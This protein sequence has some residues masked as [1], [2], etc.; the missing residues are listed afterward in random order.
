ME[1]NK[2]TTKSKLRAYLPIIG[3]GIVLVASA[4]GLGIA[5]INKNKNEAT[6]EVAFNSEF[7]TL[8]EIEA[9]ED[10]VED[11]TEEEIAAL[12]ETAKTGVKDELTLR[13]L[14]LLDDEIEI[15]VSNNMELLAGMKVNGQKTL[16]GDATL[17][18][19]LA[20]EKNT[21]ED[22]V[23]LVSRGN[24]L[25]MEGLVL[26]GNG[27]CHAILV[28]EGATL[29]YNKGTIQYASSYG[30]YNQGTTYVNGGT[31]TK[32]MSAAI[33][34]KSGA[35]TYVTGG[36]IKDNYKNHIWSAAGSTVEVTGGVFDHSYEHGIYNRGTLTMT[37]GTI[38]NS[39]S[40]NACAVANFGKAYIDGGDDYIEISNCV[41]GFFSE[42]DS[43]EV[44]MVYGHD[45]VRNFLRIKEGKGKVTNCKVENTG[46]YAVRAGGEV[47]IENIYA[48]NLGTHG[49]YISPG[50]V[51]V[52]NVEVKN[53]K[54]YGFV[55][56]GGEAT[57]T[58][59]KITGAGT[60]AFINYDS[61]FNGKGEKGLLT[62]KDCVATDC[63]SNLLVRGG[64][65]VKVSDCVF[66]KT[67]RTNVHMT[68]GTAELTN[69]KLLGASDKDCSIVSVRKDA[70]ATFTNVEMANGNRGI[71]L[72]G[73]ITVNGGSIHDNEG[74][75][76][77]NA[78]RAEDNAVYKLEGV[79]IYSNRNTSEKMAGG[80]SFMAK[81]SHG[82]IV[83]CEITNN[84]SI[85]TVGG[86]YAEKAELNIRD[87]VFKN[88]ST[89]GA[90]GK[91]GAILLEKSKSII[92]GC[93]FEENKTG[94]AYQ[95]VGGAIYSKAGS[96]LQII[97][98]DFNKNASG[99]GGAIANTGSLT[100]KEGTTFTSN[101]C[102]EGG[103]AVYNGGAGNITDNGSTYKTNTL[104]EVHAGGAIRNDGTNTKYSLVGVVLKE[105][106]SKGDGGAIYNTGTLKATDG[107]KFI[108]N[109][110]RQGGALYNKGTVTLDNAIFDE[111][112]YEG[113]VGSCIYNFAKAKLNVKQVEMKNIGTEKD[114]HAILNNG[115]TI[116]TVKD[117]KKALVIDN[118]V[119]HGVVNMGSGTTELTGVSIKDVTGADRYGVYSDSGSVILKDVAIENVTKD[120]VYVKGGTATVEDAT[121]ENIV[122]A[123]ITATETTDDD[124]NV[125][126]IGEVTL[127]DVTVKLPEDAEA[128]AKSAQ[129]GI[130]C[131]R[132]KVNVDNVNISNTNAE[133]VIN[134]GGTI[135]TVQGAE[136]SI[137]IVNANGKG[138]YSSA[139]GTFGTE[140]SLMKVVEVAGT[141]GHGVHLTE[142]SAMYIDGL[143]ITKPG[144]KGIAVQKSSATIKNTLITETLLKNEA[145]IYID[146]DS[147][148]VTM[149][150][151]TIS[152]TKG[153]GL[154][155]A[156]G[157]LLVTTENTDKQGLKVE[158]TGTAGIYI[159]KGTIMPENVVITG[160]TPAI[161]I[162]GG[163]ITD[164]VKVVPAEYKVGQIIVNGKST[165]GIEAISAL[166]DIQPNPEKP[167]DKWTVDSKG[168]LSTPVAMIGNVY[169]GDIVSALNAAV[170]NDIIT[171]VDDTTVTD[172]ITVSKS[173]TFTSNKA[174]TIGGTLSGNMF[175]VPAN[176]TL[177]IAGA[178]DA[179]KIT[180]NRQDKNAIVFNNQGTLLLKYV[181]VIGGTKGI[182][183]SGG[184]VGTTQSPIS[185]VKISNCAGHGIHSQNGGTINANGLI[186]EKPG[187][188]GIAIQ[189]ST[190]TIKN[191]IITETQNKGHAGVYIDG[192]SSK[193]T[194]DCVTISDTKGV[195]L[196]H[197][198]G[199][200]TVTCEDADKY[201]MK[202]ENAGTA[203][204]Y[205]TKGTIKPEKVVITGST[206]AIQTDGGTIE[207]RVKVVPEKYDTTQEIVTGK[208]GVE[209]ISPLVDIQQQENS[210]IT[211][212]VN[213]EGKL[214]E[215]AT[216][217][218]DIHY[219]SLEAAVVAANASAGSDEIT[220]L[221]DWTV[222]SSIEVSSTI[223][224][225]TNKAVTITGDF[226]GKT[227][228]FDVKS[229]GTLNLYGTSENPITLA[230]INTTTLIYNS[231]TANLQHL[232]LNNARRG[233]ITYKGKT[234]ASNITISNCLEHGT[235]MADGSSEMEF[236]DV[237][238][239]NV[240][241]TNGAAYGVEVEAGK[242][243]LTR[244]HVEAVN[245]TGG[246]AGGVF[247]KA[248]NVSLSSV[249]V[250]NVDGD[251]NTNF[252]IS[253]TGGTV[254]ITDS[255]VTNVDGTGTGSNRANHGVSVTGG[256]VTVSGANGITVAT[257]PLGHGIYV[258]GGSF[259]ASKIS[260]KA[261]RCG[262]YVAD[263]AVTI[264]DV[265][266][267]TSGTNTNSKGM[268]KKV[269]AHVGI[270][271]TSVTIKNKTIT[272][273]GGTD[274]Y[275]LEGFGL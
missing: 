128:G 155:H 210:T 198:G 103:A 219:P 69:V 9:L 226:S 78:V 211:W 158:N 8:G 215:A 61:T 73:K 108:G 186:I 42:D 59:I 261:G 19:F 13:L 189:G 167:E 265:G 4:I 7:M 176:K 274:Y 254:G 31:L 235:K 146:G 34:V 191:T 170:E 185:S 240:I 164:I 216:K 25:D 32:C 1:E 23:L 200:L 209:T 94:T 22:A 207:G 41:T 165:S 90:E 84:S 48:E 148:R 184:T 89:S 163:A 269:D 116:S 110:G 271:N 236:T 10:Y 18:M 3:L 134:N 150:H 91:G 145:G 147:S 83:N 212:F 174:V 5:A 213:S 203:G 63:K 98:C 204:V 206:P 80:V 133:A 221:K 202:V 96:D 183:I 143:T 82:T 129:Y 16:T 194:M 107:C 268:G 193:V 171:L 35:K 173:V 39:N 27:V 130:Y 45:I 75:L 100:M 258:T 127:K 224:F 275:S 263:V 153:V 225:K 50:K 168:L 135:N 188:K 160:S 243:T 67:I 169:Y 196:Q 230:G 132:G 101:T 29:N 199:E 106:S 267:M 137:T 104:T 172:T 15:K 229:G 11:L 246:V 111:T 12:K 149:D 162:D 233:V 105:N 72:A 66:N 142:G 234:T 179:A 52:K 36:T 112:S 76:A 79:K 43:M 237:K 231:G 227:N 115:G 177:T 55:N 257:I 92:R 197:A 214:A 139:K 33:G 249:S 114:N 218:G 260:A 65:S 117:A 119:G 120:A 47:T 159:T 125:T 71:S 138:I 259:S 175:E 109:K 14:L 232:V 49:I 157:E 54:E 181:D 154:Q 144:K 60:S 17:K 270:K 151:V 217:I 182:Y 57:A 131:V 40:A 178:S 124:K 56:V 74:E 195:G 252:G 95:N 28:Q 121:I 245:A 46:T 2:K 205:I 37:G 190:A 51:T 93:T 266:E 118:V 244:V 24:S 126:A 77:G 122:R 86:I 20:S 44:N 208:A 250:K 6:E 242:A 247:V 180:V 53:A 228:L 251:K 26:D 30:V 272:Y 21:M 253:I 273:N 255:S 256:N 87:T 58:N 99:R 264:A 136:K 38:K 123:A 152:N 64:T 241:R 161:Q 141:K 70:K 239:Q 192:S 62:L 113:N 156:G 166:V 220:L 187:Q 238:I 102:T 81:G 85:R 88:N 68:D 97:D 223:T 248:G 201:G 262:I 140:E 222:T